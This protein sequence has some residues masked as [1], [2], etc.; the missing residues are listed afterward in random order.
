[1]P[2]LYT[3]VTMK[4]IDRPKLLRVVVGLPGS[5][6]TT[7]T[8]KWVREEPWGRFRVGLDPIRESQGYTDVTDA[9]EGQEAV[10]DA[11]REGQVRWLLDLGVHVAI[12]TTNLQAG[13][14]SRWQRLASQHNANLEIVS[15]THVPVSECIRRDAERGANGGRLV[16]RS[17]IIAM[18]RTANLPVDV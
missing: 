11:A 18:A 17:V 10:V 16:G 2:K 5:G 8:L 9:A 13:I 4:R 12:D 3:P 15:F 14:L 6:K 7:E 1:M